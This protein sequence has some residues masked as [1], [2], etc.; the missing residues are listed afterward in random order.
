MPAMVGTGSEL[1]VPPVETGSPLP[2]QAPTP[3]LSSP[4]TAVMSP[5]M[6]AGSLTGPSKPW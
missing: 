3:R 2:P 1:V 4:I 5:A 6:F